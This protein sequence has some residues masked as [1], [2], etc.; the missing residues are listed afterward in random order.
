M[1]KILILAEGLTEEQFIKNVL[2][3]PSQFQNQKTVYQ[4]QQTLSWY[5]DLNQDWSRAVNGQ[6]PPLRAVAG[7]YEW[8]VRRFVSSL[9]IL[10]RR[11]ST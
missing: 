7:D 2:R 9:D 6:L 10:Y 8:A 3:H 11:L 4:L 5:P 1:K